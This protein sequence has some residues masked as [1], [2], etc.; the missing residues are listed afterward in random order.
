M[1]QDIRLRVGFHRHPKIRKLR[2]MLGAD[3]VLSLITLWTFAAEHRQKGTLEGMDTEDIALAGEWEGKPEKFV[4]ALVAVGLLDESPEGIF[5]IH[6][7]EEHQPWAYH[8]EERSEKA[9]AA[10]RKRWEKQGDTDTKRIRN[11]YESYSEGNTPSPSPSPSPTPIPTPNPKSKPFAGS[12]PKNPRDHS[13]LPAGVLPA[14]GDEEGPETEET[15][16]ARVREYFDTFPPS[17]IAEWSAEYPAVD[18]PASLL[19]AREWLLSNTAPSSR[20]KSLRRFARTW[21]AREQERGG[22][23]TSRR[24]PRGLAAVRAFRVDDE[25]GE[26]DVDLVGSVT[27]A[28]VA[29]APAGALTSGPD[30][31]GDPPAPLLD[32]ER[33]NG[34]EDFHRNVHEWGDRLKARA[35]AV[36]AAPPEEGT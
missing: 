26:E 4:R 35:A 25:D 19:R 18:V 7:W 6:G 16:K 12:D 17:I 23:A 14:G 13:P 15:Y 5:V 10:V 20:K 21:L 27:D 1:T 31:P 28:P 29:D 30:P 36:G 34:S 2:K 24:E 11:E 3:G 32:A 9:R 8:A 22:P 33:G